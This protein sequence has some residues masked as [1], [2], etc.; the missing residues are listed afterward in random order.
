MAAV[1]RGMRCQETGRR[2][3]DA[4]EMD[5]AECDCHARGILTACG[6]ATGSDLQCLPKAES[7]K[8]PAWGLIGYA[9]GVILDR[10]NAEGAVRTGVPGHAIVPGR[11]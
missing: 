8:G 4:A 2:G 10:S 3:P 6:S 11:C 5:D 1:R 9:W 7:V